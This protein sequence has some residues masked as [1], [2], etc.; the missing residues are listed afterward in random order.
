MASKEGGN[1]LTVATNNTIGG[2]DNCSVNSPKGKS[3]NMVGGYCLCSPTKHEGSFRCKF[4][5]SNNK[6]DYSSWF[7]RSNSMPNARKKFTPIAPKSVESS[8]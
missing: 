1:K 2:G 6:T 3:S 7:K 8:T 5:R 4:H